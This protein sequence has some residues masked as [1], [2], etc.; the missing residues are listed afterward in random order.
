MEYNRR[1]AKKNRKFNYLLS[2]VL[3]RCHIGGVNARVLDALVW[4]EL[5]NHLTDPELLKKHAEEWIQEQAN[6][7][8]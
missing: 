8:A 4:K 7:S 1:Y 6:R 2:E 3:C 5:T